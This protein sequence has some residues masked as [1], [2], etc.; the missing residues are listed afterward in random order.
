MDRDAL[1]VSLTN[2]VSCTVRH[3]HCERC[4]ISCDITNL[5]RNICQNLF[6]YSQN[7]E[8]CLSCVPTAKGSGCTHLPGAHKHKLFVDPENMIAKTQSVALLWAQH[9][10]SGA[11]KT[12]VAQEFERALTDLSAEVMQNEAEVRDPDQQL[13]HCLLSCTILCTTDGN[14]AWRL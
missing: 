13:G 5:E 3:K 10:H 6:F 8:H 4:E 1:S 2:V 12:I 9:K 11:F 14:K 7:K